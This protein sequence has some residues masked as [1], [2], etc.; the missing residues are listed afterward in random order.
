MNTGKAQKDDVEKEAD[1]MSA[2]KFENRPRPLLEVAEN[3]TH[4][5]LRVKPENQDKLKEAERKARLIKIVELKK[6]GD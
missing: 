2:V 3:K 6:L 4:E 5:F 1:D